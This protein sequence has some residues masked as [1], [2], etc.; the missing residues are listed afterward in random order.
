M[1]LLVE[2]D[3]SATL[4]VHDDP[5]GAA[6]FF[7]DEDGPVWRDAYG[8]I[9]AVSWNELEADGLSK[10]VASAGSAAWTAAGDGLHTAR[11]AV[12]SF[13]SAVVAP[14]DIEE[15][16]GHEWSVTTAK[17]VTEESDPHSAY[18]LGEQ[19][20]TL[21]PTIDWHAQGLVA[22]ARR[23]GRRGQEGLWHEP[24]W[25]ILRDGE[26]AIVADEGGRIHF[27]SDERHV[28]DPLLDDARSDE[29]EPESL[30]DAVAVLV[31]SVEQRRSAESFDLFELLE[32]FGGR[33]LRPIAGSPASL[34][35]ATARCGVGRL[36]REIE[37]RSPT[38]R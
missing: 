12:Y 28:R 14:R 2:P 9:T 11:S 4:A 13:I 15:S 8:G 17:F 19:F 5:N 23:A 36:R 21:E 22:T 35:A 24:L 34:L 16:D 6:L 30:A 7:D 10:L 1:S 3:G 37:N 38:R 25:L 33:D 26:P 29:T 32:L 27:P 20:P 31:R 18:S